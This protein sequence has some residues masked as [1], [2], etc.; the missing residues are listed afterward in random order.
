[1]RLCCWK[2]VTSGWLCLLFW[3]YVCKRIIVSITCKS[4]VMSVWMSTW[5]Q[6]LDPHNVLTR[7]FD[8]Q[9]RPQT[10]GA[11]FVKR[12]GV[13]GWSVPVRTSR[14]SR[15]WNVDVESAACHAL[16]LAAIFLLAANEQGKGSLSAAGG[17]DDRRK[18]REAGKLRDRT[19]PGESGGFSHTSHG[20]Q[21]GHTMSDFDSNP[22]A[23]PDFSNPFQVARLAS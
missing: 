5:G 23:D 22:F 21:K 16:I 6:H 9:T 2:T 17:G 12:T 4:N 8:I 14:C 18:Q 15:C 20:Y 7:S 3:K 19:F 11:P 1:M 10:Q 13:F